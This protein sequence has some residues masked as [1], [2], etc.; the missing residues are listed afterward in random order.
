MQHL[1]YEAP[2]LQPDKLERN[3]RLL[4]LEQSDR[5][6]D[7]FVLFSLG[8]TWLGLGR[9]TEAQQALAASVARCDARHP[10][11]PMA[12][13]MLAETYRQQGQSAEAMQACRTGR[14]LHPRNVNLLFFEGRCYR[15]QGTAEAEGCYRQLL[16]K[17]SDAYH[18][19]GDVAI[20]SVKA[21]HNLALVLRHQGRFDEA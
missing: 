5:P 6:D 1:G 12:Y 2:Q 8:Q 21:R 16:E 4:K 18:G 13:T 11:W 3:L 9:M 17:P 10:F 14:A 7:P 19:G 15:N 20:R